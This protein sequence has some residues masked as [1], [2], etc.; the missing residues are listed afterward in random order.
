MHRKLLTPLDLTKH[1]LFIE[2]HLYLRDISL[3]SF[4]T[5]SIVERM[6]NERVTGR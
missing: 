1:T 6:K 3:T 4:H 5:K 2:A